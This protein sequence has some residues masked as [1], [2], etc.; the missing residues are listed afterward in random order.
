MTSIVELEINKPKTEVERLFT[1]PANNPKWMHDLKG[2]EPISGEQGFPGSEYRLLPKKGS[3]VFT[4][5]VI[6]R[7][8]T[9][10]KLKLDAADVQVLIT[11]Q[12][13]EQSLSKTKLISKEVFTFKGLFS[14][15]GWLA[16][17]AIKSAHKKH[18]ND[19]KDFAENH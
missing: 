16:T 6:T 9:E 1:D 5:T 18:M 3:R 17:P 11:A 15:F 8:A 2:Y 4:A 14:L 10:L 13:I 12:L 19:F 7:N